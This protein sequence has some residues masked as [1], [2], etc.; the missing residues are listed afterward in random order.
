LFVCVGL[1]IAATAAGLLSWH[2]GVSGS[3]AVVF[4]CVVVAAFAVWKIGFVTEGAAT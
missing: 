2:L 4:A 1:Q 3:A